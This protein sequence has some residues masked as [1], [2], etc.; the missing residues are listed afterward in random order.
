MLVSKQV[1]PSYVAKEHGKILHKSGCKNTDKAKYIS[2]AIGDYHMADLYFKFGT[3]ICKT[4]FL[5]D[6]SISV[7]KMTQNLFASLE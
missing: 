7:H 6:A 4:H 5:M 3:C 1:N 2:H